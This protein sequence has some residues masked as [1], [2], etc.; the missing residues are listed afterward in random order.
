M[1]RFMLL[2]LGLCAGLLGALLPV[3]SA[4]LLITAGIFVTVGIF[5][6][7]CTARRWIAL[8]LIPAA[9][10]L[11]WSYG[12]QMLYLHPVLYWSGSH[13]FLEAEATDYGRFASG[14]Q[15]VT[16]RTKIGSRTLTVD[17]FLRNTDTPVQPGD[18]IS[19]QAQLQDSAGDGDYY[20]YSQGIYLTAFSRSDAEITPCTSA[21]LRYLPRLLAHRLEESAAQCFP[22]DVRGYAIALT[23]GNRTGLSIT[24]KSTL[25][26]AGIYHAL[27]LSGMHMAVLVGMLFFLRKPRHTALIGIPLCIAFSIVTGGSPSVVR[28]CVMECFLLSGNALS[29]ES[30]CPTSLS[31]AGAVLMLQNPWCILNWGLQLSFL[32]VIGIALLTGRLY[33]RFPRRRGKGLLPRLRRGMLLNL[34]VTL[35]A[36]TFTV[37]LLALYFGCVS[38][39]SPV[40]NLLTGTVISWCFGSSLLTSLIGMALPGVGRLLGS[41]L[42]WG[43]RYVLR[44]AGLLSRLPFACIYTD[45]V[46]GIAAAVLLYFILLLLVFGK[47]RRRLP[48]CCGVFGLSVCMLLLLLDSMTPSFTA[49]DVGQGQCLIFETGSGV[50]LVDCGGSTENAGTLAAD[51]LSARGVGRVRLLVLTHFD[52]DHAGGVPVLLERMDVDA[53]VIP[54]VPD[55]GRD[56]VEAAA[57][58]TGTPVYPLSSDAQGSLGLASIQF[59]SPQSFSDSNDSGLSLLVCLPG[60]S[61]LVTGDMSA[62]GESLL[63]ATHQLSAVDILVAGH[64]GSKYSTS[65]VLLDT[66]R[67]KAV[68]ISVGQNSY[69]HPSPE[70]LERIAASGAAVYR[71]D[72]SGTFRICGSRSRPL[73][74][75]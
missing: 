30:D 5:V 33:R 57:A 8:L 60:L 17:L 70:T 52:E 50:I 32:S 39:I 51:H 46:Y 53:I 36:I 4:A 38:L 27:A 2:C 37:P 62:D 20:A 75:A 71:T 47:S 44:I 15:W 3:P 68:V 65:R 35:S 66:V 25:Q 74:V 1:R 6:L 14:G 55:D 31:C 41:I 48:I 26:H 11:C 16:A 63:L 64:H 67:P 54:D 21:P 23:T 10:G 12:Y 24:D 59:Y 34:T 45:T 43:F 49:L 7:I 22:E 56:A 61:T 9:L 40:S 73:P 69:G 18:C 42:A 29:R 58:E 28:A 72:Q 19:V 13:Q